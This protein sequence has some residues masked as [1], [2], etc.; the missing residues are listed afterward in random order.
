MPKVF[1]IDFVLILTKKDCYKQC[2]LAALLLTSLTLSAQ[3]DEE[4]K[5]GRPGYSIGSGVLTKGYLQHQ[6]G[7]NGNFS[8]LSPN[9]IFSNDHVLRYGIT[10]YFEV[11]LNSTLYWTS[12]SDTYDF[13]SNGLGIGCRTRITKEKKI[14]PALALQVGINIPFTK[15]TLVSTTIIL[16]AGKNFDKGFSLTSNLIF[17]TDPIFKPYLGMTL[18]LGYSIKKTSVF[19]EAYVQ[20]FSQMS[21]TIIATGVG[22]LF[23]KNVLWDLHGGYEVNNNRTLF[24]STGISWRIQ[25][26]KRTN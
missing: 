9:R 22:Y 3:T 6:M 16:S 19:V 23:H 7:V 14:L 12:Q 17:K 11:S 26:K 4:I 24:V 5:T 18:N 15:P 13:S 2:I 20:N 1:L 10:D 8:K 21:S 25:L